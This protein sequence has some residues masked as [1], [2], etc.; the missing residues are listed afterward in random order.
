MFQ[1]ALPESDEEDEEVVQEEEQSSGTGSSDNWD[2]DELSSDDYV[3]QQTDQD[4]RADHF[5]GRAIELLTRIFTLRTRSK[6]GLIDSG[7]SN[8]IRS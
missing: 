3:C 7:H 6:R 5:P 1:E 2:G 8:A 4:A